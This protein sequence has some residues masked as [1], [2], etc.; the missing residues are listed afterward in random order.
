MR[1]GRKISSDSAEFSKVVPAI[2]VL[3]ILG[4]IV[5][6]L[7]F[8]RHFLPALALSAIWCLVL[9]GAR[10]QANRLAEEAYLAA[11][12]FLLKLNGEEVIIPFSQV[13]CVYFQ[14][15]KPDVIG[16]GTKSVYPLSEDLRFVPEGGTRMFSA[17]SDHP[18]LAELKELVKAARPPAVVIGVDP[19]TKS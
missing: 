3:A 5:L 14:P 6:L 13:K 19:R 15:G 11:D 17:F 16:I 9:W 4:V 10:Y 12:H 1:V 8:S 18:L 7:L 2:M